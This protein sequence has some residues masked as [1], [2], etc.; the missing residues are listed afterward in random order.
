MKSFD[1]INKLH[2]FF[3]WV[4]CLLFLEQTSFG[5]SY[6]RS[7]TS[8]DWGQVATW[9]S[10]PTAGGPWTPAV[11]TPT[12]TDFTVTILS[13]HI[14]RIKATVTIDEVT[15]NVG[16]TLIANMTTVLNIANGTG[17]DLTINGT[18]KDSLN[19]SNITFAASATW[20][21]GAGGTLIKVTNSSSNNWQ[22][23]Y[24]TGIANIPSTANW[25]VRKEGTLNPSISTTNGGTQAYYPNLIIEN[26]TAGLYNTN[27][28][29]SNHFNGN[30]SYP[31]IKGN[32]DVGGTGSSTVDFLSNDLNPTMGVQ[33]LGYM[34]VRAGNFYRNYGTG[35][36]IRGNLTVEGTFNYDASD[37]RKLVFSGGNAQG[38][39]G[40]GALSVYYMEINKTA[41]DLTLNRMVM[42]DNNMNFVNR[43]IITT[44]ANVL[45]INDNA[46]ATG[47]SNSSYVEGPCRKLGD[48]AFDFPVGKGGDYQLCGINGAGAPGITAFWTENFTNG[49]TQNCLAG[50]YTGPNGTWTVTNSGTNGNY[51][52]EWFISCAENGMP[53]GSC[54]AGC[55]NNASLHV[56]NIP[57]ALCFLCPTG[58]CGATYNAGP[59]FGG[60]NPTADKRAESPVISTIGKST[61]TLGFNYI[62][63]GQT[64]LD[65][66]TVEYSINGGTTWALL[67]NPG[68]TPA[69]CAPQGTWTAFTVGLPTTCDNISNLKIGFRWIN[70]TDG[71]GSDPSVAIDNVTLSAAVPDSYTAEYF[72][73]N[74]TVV[75]NNVVNLPLDHVSKCEYWIINRDFGTQARTVKLSWDANS[76]G[77]TNLSDLR[78]AYF[79]SAS[80][81][82]KG[83]TAT[84]GTTASGTVTSNSQ[85]N[86]GPFTLA[87]VNSNNPLPVELL[88]FTGERKNKSVL[89]KWTTSSELNNDYFTLKR[90]TNQREFFSI[91]KIQGAGTSS[92]QHNYSFTDEH[93]ANGVNYYELLQ[94][95]FDGSVR[96][97]G[98]VAVRFDLSNQNIMVTSDYA[99]QQIVVKL[100][101]EV[102]DKGSIEL[103]DDLGKMIS[104]KVLDKRNNY[105]FNTVSL[106][107][108]IYLLRI[109][110]KDEVVYKR[111]FY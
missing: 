72:K 33:I 60:Q 30:V 37:A 44:T 57:C 15:V 18:F 59:T 2:R 66:F 3:A 32:F 48:D 56:G 97:N 28:T 1:Y 20:V 19:G 88:S 94:T 35:T 91:A 87:S 100:D 74:P 78:V 93:P 71:T 85:N 90:S 23:A 49:C 34:V 5:Q 76:C 104:A 64:T 26:N 29:T 107:N 55:G 25:I 106:S 6:Y 47:A 54:G 31:I 102:F 13:G 98:V 69:T 51:A 110:S 63:N 70:N 109:T 101:D 52:N 24:S 61:I 45:V 105:I 27:V 111:F 108:G 80:W 41:N 82:D 11:A 103:M 7:F 92:V 89:L 65:N 77:V 75:Y 73:A 42:V 84:T 12:S 21:I 58:D 99:A 8:G 62:E 79:N 17:V 68:K 46:T 40:A 95:D 4:V 9:E 36:E 86:W 38:I 67:T 22:S 14:V 83:N 43:K 16:G 81:D 96:G 53:A 10:G 39:Y 50:S